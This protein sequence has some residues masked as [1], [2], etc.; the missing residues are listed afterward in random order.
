MADAFIIF[1]VWYAKFLWNSTVGASLKNKNIAIMYACMVAA[2]FLSGSIF[3]TVWFMIFVIF[4]TAVVIGVQDLIKC[5]PMRKRRKH[6]FE[7]FYSMNFK[8]TDNLYPQF[9][10]EEKVS[11]YTTVISFATYIS[12]DRWFARKS[13]F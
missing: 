13:D 5:A 9:I 7:I 11:E 10:A 8:G 3:G 6:F 2:L 4:T 1:I 12:L